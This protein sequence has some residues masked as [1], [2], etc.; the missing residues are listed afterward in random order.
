LLDRE[1]A[2]ARSSASL[3]VAT[4]DPARIERL[5]SSKLALA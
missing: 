5:A 4:H 3:I 1:L 2:E